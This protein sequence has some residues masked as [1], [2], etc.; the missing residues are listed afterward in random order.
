MRFS[1]LFVGAIVLLGSCVSNKKVVL[2]Q[3]D[4]LNIEG[5][6]KDTIVRRYALDTFKYKI[7]ANDILWVKF[8]S[9]TDKDFDFISDNVNP[10]QTGNLGQGNALLLGE[11]VDENGEIPFPVIG[12][13]KVIGLTVFQVQDSLQK[14]A[15]LYFESPVVKVRLLNYRITLLG[16]VAREG[17]ITLANNRTTLLE[18]LGLAGGLGEL[19]DRENIKLIR[20]DGNVADIQYIN[21][22]DENFMTSPYYYV[23]QNDVIIV[24]PLKQRPFRK[25]FGQNISLLVSSLSILLLAFNLIK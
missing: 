15:N 12:N 13:I 9:L 21:L 19:A 23:N 17:S 11:L 1:L 18:A 7:Q 6:K 20:Q 2:L 3:K 16:E 14:V 8:K 10:N 4:D 25:Y 24:P 5:L 22:L